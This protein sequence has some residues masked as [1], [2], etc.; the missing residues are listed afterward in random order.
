MKERKDWKIRRKRERERG[1]NGI[2]EE[3]RVS[4][5]EK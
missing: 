5:E 2:E 1:G 3:R 4:S